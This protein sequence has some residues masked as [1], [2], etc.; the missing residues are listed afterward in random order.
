MHVVHIAGTRFF[1]LNGCVV[2]ASD[3]KPPTAL[4]LRSIGNPAL[5][6]TCIGIGSRCFFATSALFTSSLPVLSYF[7][8]TYNTS[9][10]P[11]VPPSCLRA[12]HERDLF[13]SRHFVRGWQ[14]LLSYGKRQ[15]SGTPLWRQLRLAVRWDHP[16]YHPWA[17]LRPS[18][19]TLC[20]STNSQ[21]RSPGRF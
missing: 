17:A 4:C 10:L 20:G 14:N 13:S 15:L 7:S 19:H 18:Y 16:R 9:T 21:S 3:R 5:G 1:D 12:S 2:G 6:N 11:S 8:R